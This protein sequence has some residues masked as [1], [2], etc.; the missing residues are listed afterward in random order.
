MAFGA[1]ERLVFGLIFNAKRF[2][3]MSERLLTRSAGAARKSSKIFRR[4]VGDGDI[5]TDLIPE[6]IVS[7]GRRV[8]RGQSPPQILCGRFQGVR[9]SIWIWIIIW[10]PPGELEK[11]R[12]EGYSECGFECVEHEGGGEGPLECVRGRHVVHGAG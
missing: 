9:L 11:R 2:A 4:P 3:V 12:L 1:S 5:P 7:D 8:E 10:E 6:G